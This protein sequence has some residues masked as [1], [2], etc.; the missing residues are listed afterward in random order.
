MK[1]IFTLSFTKK[2]VRCFDGGLQQPPLGV[3]GLNKLDP[4]NRKPTLYTF[5][6]QSTSIL[7]IQLN[8]CML[9]S[10]FSIQLLVY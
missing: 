5:H 7:S 4:G 10:I 2:K 3:R 9:T 8:D 6:T 1:P